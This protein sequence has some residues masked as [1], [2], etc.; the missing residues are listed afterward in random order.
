ML[1]S[2]L[3]KIIYSAIVTG[4]LILIGGCQI[5]IPKAR[6]GT[7]PTATAGSAFL[8]PNHLGGHSYF[9]SPLEKNGIVYTCKTGHIDLTHL[10]WNADYTLYAAKRTRKALMKKRKGFSFTIV[11]ER[12][13]HKMTFGYPENWDDLSHDEKSKIAEE[14]S[15]HTG[16]YIAYN[17]TLWHEILTWF[18]VRFI[19]IEPEFHSSFSWEDMYSNLI[20]TKLAIEAMQD[21]NHSYSKA[22]T[23]AIDR[24]LERLGVQSRRTAID[25]AKKMKGIWFKGGT[26]VTGNFFVKTMKKNLDIGLG[27]GFVT[28][29][30]VDGICEGVKPEPLAVPNLDI[31]S[32]YGL[33]MKYEIYMSEWE[34]GRILKAAH[35]GGKGKTVEP[36]KHFPAI[37]EFIKK[38]AVEKYGYIID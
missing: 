22:M 33:T 18:G 9:Y 38:E 30:I 8:D 24:E 23:L 27:D 31:L 12:S 29:T 34:K 37:M 36:D 5:G 35:Q 10:R 21:P 7:L 4:F 15:L 19:G 3:Q 17:A 28:P 13:K 6:F 14:V 25:A 26:P 11:M 1:I 20:G 16:P 32:K 2:T